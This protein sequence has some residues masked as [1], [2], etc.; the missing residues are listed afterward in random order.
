MAYNRN[1][2]AWKKGDVISSNR[3]NNMEEGI[4]QALTDATTQTRGLTIL[5][6]AIDSTSTTSSATPEAV[7]AALAAAKT[8]STNK[9]NAL[10]K[11]DSEVAGQ[12]VS[13]VSEA[14]GIITT[15]KASFNP[16]ISFTAGTE[17][18]APQLSINVASTGSNP[19][20]LSAATTTN[21]GTTILSNSTSSSSQTQAAT[22]KAVSDALSAALNADLTLGT[23]STNAYRGDYGQ[24]AYNHAVLKGAAYS[25]GIYKITTNSEGHVTAATPVIFETGATEGT[26]S[27]DGVDIAVNG[28]GSAAYTNVVV[29]D[30]EG[31]DLPNPPVNVGTYL[32]QLTIGENNARTYEWVSAPNANGVSF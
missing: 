17:S 3:L 31:S 20:T 30:G 25:S 9:I 1:E 18:A 5:S 13:A 10:D 23:N 4:K 21:Y 29:Y 11:S 26:I 28:L 6:N 16:S 8:D 2:P 12:Y 7:R 24:I 22:S 32:L 15:S 14:N 19:V 27:I